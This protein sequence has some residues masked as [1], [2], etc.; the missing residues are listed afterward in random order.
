MVARTSSI[1]KLVL[2][3]IKYLV[4]A[5]EVGPEFAPNQELE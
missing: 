2:A 3:T 5:L 1:I 4:A